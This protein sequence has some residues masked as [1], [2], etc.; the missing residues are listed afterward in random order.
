MEFDFYFQ[1]GGERSVLLRLAELDREGWR[2][3]SC[4]REQ[5]GFLILVARSTGSPEAEP[6]QQVPR[7]AAWID[8]GAA[9][10]RVGLSEE[11]IREA[12]LGG[13]LRH[14]RLGRLIRLRPEW[15]DAWVEGHAREVQPPTPTG[16]R[17]LS[18]E[19]EDSAD[20]V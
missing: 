13:E 5:D 8:V 2:V 20:E 4:S 1:E 18:L 3:V 6:G 14:A 10:E 17:V 15:V 9:A 16:R 12:C 7:E 19:L 11:R